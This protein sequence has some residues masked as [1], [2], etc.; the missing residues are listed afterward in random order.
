[1]N[2]LD[3]LL[4]RAEENAATENIQKRL[5]AVRFEFDTLRHIST[6]LAL[7]HAFLAVPEQET[8]NRL[9]DALDARHAWAVAHTE[10]GEF[11][12]RFIT[13]HP[14]YRV[15]GGRGSVNNTEPFDW[16]TAALRAADEPW[17]PQPP[18]QAKVIRATGA[19]TLN[20]PQ[21][22]ETPHYTLQP[23]AGQ[24]GD[25]RETTNFR[26]LYDDQNLYIRV[27]GGLPAELMDTFVSRG[28]DAELWLQES[29]NILLAPEGDRSQ[30]Y[31]LTYEPVED[32][33][34]DANHGY[35]TDPLHPVFG[36]ND[37]TWDGRWEYLND[38]Q[39]DND[40]WLSMAVIPYATL[41][42]PKPT[43]GTIWA[44]NIGRVHFF[45]RPASTV[46]RDVIAARETAVWT[47][48][49][50]GSRNPGDADM[51]DIQF[52]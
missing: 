8:F 5:E 1:M 17:K 40:R 13:V 45:A 3:G 44:A 23:D 7:Y 52:E 11:F 37:Q 28:R 33:F 48:R 26:M 49:L 43:P 25:L 21:W 6:V 9:L 50:T 19:V 31:Y 51:G 20:S 27:E 2:E 30:Y 35:I 36:W 39:P 29:I 34:I 46:H 47:G 38:L 15:S 18:K 12:D 24:E 10:G 41:N 14:G 22:A 42:V 32:S 4:T 16:D